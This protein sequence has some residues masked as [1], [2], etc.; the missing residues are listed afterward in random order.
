MGAHQL[1]VTIDQDSGFCFGVV[2]AIDMA[3]DILNEDGYLYCLGDI[4]HN[5]EEVDRLKAKGLRI[6][7]HTDLV[8]L[9]NEKV[10]IRAHGEAP[11]T[12]KI[13]LEN[14][15]TL[16]DASCPVVLKL[17]NRIKTSFDQDEDIVIFGKHGHAEVIG[18]QGQTDGRALVFQDISELD[19]MELPQRF[20]LY[21]Q[22][23]K[24]TAKFYQIKEELQNRGYDIKAN[25][26]IC[27]Q[28]SNRDRDLPEFAV[29]FNKIVFVSGKKSSNGKVLFEVCR[30]YNPNTYFISSVDEIDYSLFAEGDTVGIAGAT[31]TPM[32]LME[33]VKAALENY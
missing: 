23:T 27:R 20:T 26:T 9:H 13:A 14:N 21:S 7:A 10:L 19:T 25:D 24:S 30:K 28:V 15:I 31:S 6:I 33:E 18:L 29:K 8:N 12:Y 5:D 2:Y 3:E 32:W 16:I 22:T 1:K 4:V 11:E 17:Q